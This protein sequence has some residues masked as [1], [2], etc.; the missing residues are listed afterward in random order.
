M[1][2]K[3][4]LKEGQELVLA[5]SSKDGKPNANLV[6]SNGLVDDKLLVSDCQMTT[7]IKNLQQNGR[8]CVIAKHG[9]EYY[10]IR[11][12]VTIYSSGKY[13]DLAVKKST[14]EYPVKH[15]ILI[16]IKEVFDLDKGKNI[17]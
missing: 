14:P 4:A 3:D 8:I 11:G 5:T 13:F 16:E 2:W 6:I 12:D 10:R 7:T 15:A 17:L 1:A 9:K